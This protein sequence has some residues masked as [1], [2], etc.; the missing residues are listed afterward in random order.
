[1]ISKG[2][3]KILHGA[4]NW[5]IGYVRKKKMCPQYKQRGKR[6]RKQGMENEKSSTSREIGEKLHDMR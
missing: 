1:M 5:A 3:E 6:G 4:L 2:R